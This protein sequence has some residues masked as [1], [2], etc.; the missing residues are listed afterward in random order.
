MKISHLLFSFLSITLICSNS[1]SQQS[2]DTD[3]IVVIGS[4]TIE[5]PADRVT[6]NIQLSFSDKLDAKKAYDQHKEAE[7]QLVQLFRD[8]HI[9]DSVITYSLLSFNREPD[10]TR[11]SQ[12][13][14]FRTHQTVKILMTDISACPV[15]ELKLVSKGFVS[16]S[17]N[18]ESSKSSWAE[19]EAIQMAVKQARAKAE[20]IAEAAGRKIKKVIKISDTEDT[21]P[22]IARYYEPY[23]RIMSYSTAMPQSSLSAIPQILS[24]SKQIK[25]IFELAN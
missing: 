12:E 25:A 19:K 17:E 13:Q 5:V 9:P 8:S 6:M 4:A 20:I 16:L 2:N 18:Y 24:V 7:S 22:I 14:V 10:Y 3:K 11:Q 23:A 15:F 21:E 1:L